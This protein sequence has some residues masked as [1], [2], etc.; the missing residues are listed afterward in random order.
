[1]NEPKTFI[2][3]TVVVEPIADSDTYQQQA[4]R[5]LIDKPEQPL[6][7]SEIGILA[8]VLA[9]H[10]R[11]GKL[12]EK[13]K[14]NI[15]HRHQGYDAGNFLDDGEK[16]LDDLTN[17]FE[18]GTATQL[19]LTDQDTMVLWNVIGLLGEASEIAKLELDH[20]LKPLPE[21]QVDL[22][23]REEWTKELGDVAWYHAAIA[24][25]L[26]LQLSDIQGANIAKFKKRF[27]DG[28][29]ADASIERVDVEGDKSL[30]SLLGQA[31]RDTGGRVRFSGLEEEV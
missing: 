21:A 2:P 25:K 20:A 22:A 5:T 28:F 12:T 10:E 3:D 24:T 23:T 14:K 15:L 17:I 16:L 9:M 13:L 6:S 30:E 27:P 7:G 1:M 29:T 11:L 4:A 26:G 18:R 8:T 19:Q 31:R